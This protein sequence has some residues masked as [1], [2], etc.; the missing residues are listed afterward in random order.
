MQR[1]P[2]VWLSAASW[3]C[4]AFQLRQRHGG[5]VQVHPQQLQQACWVQLVQGLLLAGPLPPGQPQCRE[6]LPGPACYDQQQAPVQLQLQP[7]AGPC[8]MLLAVLALLRQALQSHQHR[9]AGPGPGPGCGA[10]H[11]APQQG[12]AR[13]VVSLPLLPAPQGSQRCLLLLARRLLLQASLLRQVG[14]LGLLPC[15]PCSP[16]L[17]GPALKPSLLLLLLMVPNAP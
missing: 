9:H 11:Q 2:Q 8:W 3:L 6:E 10:S 13:E 7:R 5:L 4:W 14:A 16:A 17:V 15:A 1:C 12:Q